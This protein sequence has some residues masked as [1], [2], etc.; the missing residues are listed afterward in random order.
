MIEHCESR[1][2]GGPAMD[3]HDLNPGS[4]LGIGRQVAGRLGLAPS[5]EVRE[6]RELIANGERAGGRRALPTLSWP[7]ASTGSAVAY[8]PE[9]L[10]E[11]S[12]EEGYM[13]EQ[14]SAPTVTAIERQFADDL[15]RF[16]R[17]HGYAVD[18][19]ATTG[20][21][22]NNAAFMVLAMSAARDRGDT[23]SASGRRCCRSRRRRCS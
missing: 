11:W 21:R 9:V 5:S 13:S 23:T 3:R 17:Y 20:H 2:Y 4:M 14:E 16:C 18:I 8:R 12:R 7:A 10:S 1:R 19:F 22:Y 6:H 15:Q